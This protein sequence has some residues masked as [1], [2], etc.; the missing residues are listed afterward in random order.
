MA[1]QE[2]VMNQHRL[3]VDEEIIQEDF[4]CPELKKQLF[5][6]MTRLKKDRG[7]LAF[8]DRIDAVSIAV[9]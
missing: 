2:P 1:G 5:Y 4:R 7:S 8:D 3:I 9:N 6:Q